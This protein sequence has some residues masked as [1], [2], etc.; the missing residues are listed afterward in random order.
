ML[1][2]WSALALGGCGD[3]EAGVARTEASPA[4]SPPPALLEHWRKLAQGSRGQVE[5]ALE[6]KLDELHDSLDE[7]ILAA[8]ARGAH[9]PDDSVAELRENEARLRAQLEA[10]GRESHEAWSGACEDMQ[11]RAALWE[12]DCRRLFEQR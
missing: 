9:V 11:V 6:Q 4:T 5:R 2:A 7:W 3:P 8:K 1:A 12:E 10:L